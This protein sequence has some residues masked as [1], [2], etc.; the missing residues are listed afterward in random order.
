MCLA[1]TAVASAAL[2][3]VLADA[4]HLPPWPLSHDGEVVGAEPD[5]AADGARVEPLGGGLYRVAPDAGVQEVRLRAGS[6][7]AVAPVEPPAG[8]I[9]VRARPERPVKGRDAEVAL[10]LA[11]L[12]PRGEPDPGAAPPILTSSAGAVR[13]LRPVGPGRFT[14]RLEMPAAR[15]PELAVILALSPRCPLCPTPW[16]VGTAVLPLTGAAVVPGRTD[17]NVKVT[18]EIAGRTFGP[19]VADGAG[20]FDVPVEVPPG[21]RYGSGVSEDR[22]G[23]R[24]TEVLDLR[25]PPIVRIACAA[26][27]PAL[28]ADGRA[29]AGV[30]CVASDARGRPAPGARLELSAQAGRV[31][32]LEPLGEGLFRAR[33]TAPRGRGGGRDRLV[34]AYP[35]G[36]SASRVEVVLS[37]APGPPAELGYALDREPVPVGQAIGAR[38]WARDDRGDPLPAPAGPPGSREGFVAPDRFVAR[39]E[40]GNW[41]QRAPLRLE[42]PAASAAAA[43]FLRSDGAEWVA[44][45]RGLDGGP[46]AGLEIRFGSGARAVTDA[47]GDAREPAVG[48]SETAVAAGGARAAA[49]RGFPAAVPPVALERIFE[50]ALGPEAEVDVRASVD[51]GYLRWKVRDPQ[52]R[53]LAGRRVRLEASGVRLGTPEPD[54]EG[55]RC[56]A[57]GQGTA[58]VVDAETGIAAVVEVR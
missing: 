42:L 18:V 50:I 40:P 11:V 32:R 24:R 17:P 44:S 7:T 45:A 12:G 20:H 29:G 8:R 19:V 27:P 56:R 9:V 57:E 34:A 36:G 22:L 21:E 35:D 48:P 3:L 13:D 26:W 41:V 23:N 10:D 33:Y 2:Q 49:W 4:V 1:L 53:V 46:A 15:H 31:T 25:L 16:A 6:A 5:L 30:W 54:G 39:A 28:P 52:G 51:G 38:T 58:T 14:A 55:G 37:L 47:R 43:L